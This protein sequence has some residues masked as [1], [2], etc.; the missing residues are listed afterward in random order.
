MTI[1]IRV[2][3]DNFEVEY[4]GPEAFLEGKLQEVVRSLSEFERKASGSG[5]RSDAARKEE[6]TPGTPLPL[7]LKSDKIK[8]QADRFLATAVWLRDEKE[9]KSLKTSDVTRA[10][11]DSQERRLSNA[12]ECL[13]V[14]IGKGYCEIDSRKSSER[15]FYVTAQGREHIDSM[16]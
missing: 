3:L 5:Q 8:S 2:K 1:K 15:T 4:D 6:R 14:N 10:L 11:K 13:N 12:S 9:Q 7:F 16:K